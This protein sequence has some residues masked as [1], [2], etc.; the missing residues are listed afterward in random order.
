[1]DFPNSIYTV[2]GCNSLWPTQLSIRPFERTPWR[3]LFFNYFVFL[4]SS[5]GGGGGG[6]GGASKLKLS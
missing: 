5:G 3:C 1:M 4:F 6:G 2:E